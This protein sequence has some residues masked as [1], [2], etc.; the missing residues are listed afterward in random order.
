MLAVSFERIHRSN[1]VGMGILPLELPQAK[2]WDLLGLTG[3][4][5]F[6][7]PISAI[8]SSRSRRSASAPRSR[9]Q[10]EGVRLQGPHRYTGGDGLLSQWRD[11]ADGAAEAGE[12]V[13]FVIAEEVRG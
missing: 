4:E 2:T 3:E 1:L 13:V 9:R 8:G 6:E 5:I 12:G 11:F 10:R 7:V